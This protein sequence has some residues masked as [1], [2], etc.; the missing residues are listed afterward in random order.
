M[1]LTK[2]G[3]SILRDMIEQ[4][5]KKKGEEVF[6][7]T[8]NKQKSK[9]KIQNHADK[10]YDEMIGQSPKPKIGRKK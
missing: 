10:A 6:Y 9:G 4:Y 2:K 1:P 5:G 3:K 8:K 7:A